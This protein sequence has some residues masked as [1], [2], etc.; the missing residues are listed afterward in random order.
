MA[1]SNEYRGLGLNGGIYINDTAAKSRTMPTTASRC[2]L[3]AAESTAVITTGFLG[4]DAEAEEDEEEREETFI[5]ARR[6]WSAV[7]GNGALRRRW[8]AESSDDTVYA[9]DD[10]S[11]VSCTGNAPVCTSFTIDLKRPGGGGGWGEQKF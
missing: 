1:S 9:I 11:F 8:M 10:G 2:V 7:V 4:D 3:A 6:R 5:L